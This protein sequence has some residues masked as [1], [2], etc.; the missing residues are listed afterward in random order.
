MA[1]LT[2]EQ[3][4]SNNRRAQTVHRLLPETVATVHSLLDDGTA[5][6][7]AADGGTGGEGTASCV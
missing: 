4:A 7:A 2:T 1:R 3:I 5:A 6:E